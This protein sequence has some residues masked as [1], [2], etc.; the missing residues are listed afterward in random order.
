MGTN[1]EKPAPATSADETSALRPECKHKVTKADKNRA[2][3]VLGQYIHYF[4]SV[5]GLYRNIVH[6]QAEV[7]SRHG[8]HR[9]QRLSQE[10]QDQAFN[11]YFIKDT[12]S[13]TQQSGQEKESPTSIELEN[14]TLPDRR[15]S[16][17]SVLDHD[18]FSGP[19]TWKSKSIQNLAFP[20]TPELTRA[21]REKEGSKLFSNSA[22][23]QLKST[24]TENAENSDEA[25]SLVT[26]EQL[27]RTLVRNYEE[28]QL[29]REKIRRLEAEKNFQREPERI[30]KHAVKK[31]RSPSHTDPNRS[32][33]MGGF[34]VSPAD[35]K[36]ATRLRAVN[37]D[38]SCSNSE[39]ECSRTKTEKGS[40]QS[41]LSPTFA[42]QSKTA[43]GQ[44]I[45]IES[46]FTE[47]TEKIYP[48][49]KSLD[50]DEI[51][52]AAEEAHRKRA[53]SSGIHYS[54]SPQHNSKADRRNTS[55]NIT[56]ALADSKSMN[57]KGRSTREI[58]TDAALHVNK[59]YTNKVIITI[60]IQQ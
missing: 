21:P 3:A 50:F 28:Q 38:F 59:Q 36:N 45:F 25:K 54:T 12:H 6:M 41:F 39:L 53:E 23:L 14:H 37:K 1:T 8:K 42:P 16:L 30:T 29:A 4:R 47:K 13:N 44:L 58:P 40:Q 46:N 56:S 32:I 26:I 11:S 27:R 22:L 55:S 5:N 43:T 35:L 33:T 60:L 48:N 17:Q 15:D 7:V 52:E 10:H 24:S 9:W 19:F 31:R 57:E 20:S 51:L 2:L 34:P 49:R 18:S